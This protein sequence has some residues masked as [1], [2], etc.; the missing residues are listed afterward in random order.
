MPLNLA[1]LQGSP[2][3][4][5]AGT[6]TEASSGAQAALVWA[7]AVGAWATAILPA[8]AAVAAA[9]SA[10]QAALAGLFATPRSSAPEVA[11]LAAGMETA[12]LTF[13]TAV[14]LGM[15]GYAPTPPIGPV[16]FIDILTSD[17]RDDSQDAADEIADALDGWMKTGI[18]TLI[19]PPFTVVAW[20]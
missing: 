12:H 4:P 8:S 2:G 18:G 11:T 13:A 10:L 7:T 9:Q 1:A 20:S 19:A 3:L 15:A 5:G 14:G 16:G 17:P 6:N